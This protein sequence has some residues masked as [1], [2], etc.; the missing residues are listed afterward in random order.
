MV[1]LMDSPQLVFWANQPTP[2][3]A[4]GL[5]INGSA[6]SARIPALSAP[7]HDL[8]WSDVPG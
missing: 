2:K 5:R 3:Q 7:A 8:S 1:T 6:R 4:D